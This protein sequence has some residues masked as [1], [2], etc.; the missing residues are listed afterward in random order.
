M[1]SRV[2]TIDT[3]LWGTYS[4]RVHTPDYDGNTPRVEIRV[5]T[6][7]ILKYLYELRP[8]EAAV[9]LGRVVARD[10][11]S[12]HVDENADRQ[13]VAS[14]EGADEPGHAE[15]EDQEAHRPQLDTSSHAHLFLYRRRYREREQVEGGWVGGGRG[16]VETKGVLGKEAQAPGHAEEYGP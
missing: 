3:L 6:R 7:Y 15:E 2:C 9:N 4:T 13:H 5:D 16:F 14:L 8:S 10:A 1:L 12:E 11:A